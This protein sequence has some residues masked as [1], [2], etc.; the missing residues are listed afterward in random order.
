MVDKEGSG[1]ADPR[2]VEGSF[3]HKPYSSTDYKLFLYL[4]GEE[5][6]WE[7]TSEAGRP[8]SGPE[9]LGNGHGAWT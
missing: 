8:G 6:E 5:W 1:K 7:G 2:A 9:L 3:M 4:E